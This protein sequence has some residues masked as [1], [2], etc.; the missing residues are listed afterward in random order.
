MNYYDFWTR[1]ELE[2]E[3]ARCVKFLGDEQLK[4]II[5]RAES[6]LDHEWQGLF[7]CKQSEDNEKAV[8]QR[9]REKG[10]FI[11]KHRNG[12][13]QLMRFGGGAVATASS[14]AE[15]DRCLSAS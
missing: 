2:R 7:V 9:A 11:R 5:S 12:M 13:Y 10:F 8:R 15:L 6:I 4:Q 3:A 14:I 1:K